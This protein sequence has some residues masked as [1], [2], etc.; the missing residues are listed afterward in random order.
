[1]RKLCL[2]LLVISLLLC[3][4]PVLADSESTVTVSTPVKMVCTGTSDGNYTYSV[5]VNA[6]VLENGNG[7]SKEVSVL[8]FGNKDNSSFISGDTLINLTVETIA[9]DY[10]IYYIDQK[11]SAT[12]GSLAFSFSVTF[13]SPA[14]TDK[15]Y[16]WLGVEGAAEAEKYSTEDLSVSSDVVAVTLSADNSS[17]SAGTDITLTPTFSNVFG[18]S[19]EVDSSSFAYIVTQN[20]SQVPASIT[21]NIIFTGS[22]VGDYVVSVCYTNADGSTVVSTG[23]PLSVS[24]LSGN[25]PGDTNGDNKITLTDAI[26][27]LSHVAELSTLNQ[28]AQAAADVDGTAGITLSDAEKILKFIARIILA[29]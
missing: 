14:S 16:L 7:A 4:F 6:T 18:N 17:V 3:S 12:D 15:Y 25:R 26:D 22:L 11:T 29:F 20:N 8:M 23:T 19:V 1:M 28:E 27:I 10:Y 13:P 24:V 21:N 2:F 9:A 5:N